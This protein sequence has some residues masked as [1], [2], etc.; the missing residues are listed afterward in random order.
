MLFHC[1]DTYLYETHK[2]GDI[3]IA[4]AANK[5]EEIKLPR[6]SWKVSNREYFDNLMGSQATILGSLLRNIYSKIKSTMQRDPQ[7]R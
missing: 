4:C 3:D 5:G 2:I 1:L 6:K 7:A